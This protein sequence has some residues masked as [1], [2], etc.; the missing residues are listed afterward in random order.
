[1]KPLASW[2]VGYPAFLSLFFSI[3]GPNILVAKLINVVLS[4][5]TVLFTYFIGKQIFTHKIAILAT[6]FLTFLPGVIVYTSLLSTDTLFMAL[7]SLCFVLVL[8]NGDLRQS[9]ATPW[10][11]FFTGLTNG[12]LSL[13]RG[14]GLSIMPVLIFTYWL[15]I[16]KKARSTIRWA[17][18]AVVSMLCVVLP[19]TI[20][21]YVHFNKIILVSTNDGVNFWIGNNPNAYGGYIFPRDPAINPI[22]PLIG[23]DIAVR[24]TGFQEGFIFIRENPKKVI[25]L[26]P[27]KIFYLYNSN[28]FG[29]HWNKLS[30][31]NTNQM[32]TGTRAY[33]LT[34]LAYTFLALNAIIGVAYL[35]FRN[36]E[37]YPLKWLGVL[38]TIYWT[39]IHL[40]FFGQDRFVLPLIPFLTIYASLGIITLLTLN[41]VS[42]DTSKH[43]KPAS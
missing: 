8:K 24:E 19:W 1:M 23:D 35:L 28:D 20:R 41:N 10:N 29:L 5:L 38:F 18:I 34:N 25:S 15:T 17:I 7:T 31:I 27:A 42:R 32:G 21:N 26:V 2:P 36:F 12:F 3:T 6:I 16:N 33:A 39:I 22:F 30:A 40:P 13:V 43:V 9:E 4:T 37:M 14:V 11:P